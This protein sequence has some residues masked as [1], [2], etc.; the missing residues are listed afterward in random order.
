MRYDFNDVYSHLGE[1]K[2][3]IDDIKIL[4]K[5]GKS[6]YIDKI[7]CSVDCSVMIFCQTDKVKGIP[8][9]K[10]II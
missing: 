3:T 5:V 1:V 4:R 6:S 8:I 10:K 2:E 9:S 7:I